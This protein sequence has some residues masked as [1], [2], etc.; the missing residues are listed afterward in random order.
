MAKGDDAMK[1]F[2]M[3]T[4][5]MTVSIA[6]YTRIA[7]QE[8]NI[9]EFEFTVVEK[10]ST[11]TSAL[12]PIDSGAVTKTYFRRSDGTSGHIIRETRNGRTATTANYLSPN[13][14]AEVVVQV[15][16][17][18]QS[19]YPVPPDVVRH[20]ISPPVRSQC[21]GKYNG[22][23]RVGETQLFGV[24]VEILRLVSSDEEGDFYVAPSLDCATLEEHHKWKDQAGNVVSLTDVELV[25]LKLGPPSPTYFELD[26]GAR[27]AA[28]SE[29]RGVIRSLLFPGEL[30]PECWMQVNE[31]VDSV[32]HR[33]REEAAKG[34]PRL[35]IVKGSQ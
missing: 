24:P 32:Y 34:W 35:P 33:R 4:A 6:M 30:V 22:S 12:P 10:L 18:I 31:R 27:E 16:G 26:A 2:L 5:I 25:D 29:A 14:S 8:Q 7:A 15:E 19:T 9:G 20:W 13:R 21:T 3:A 11:V 1:R 23:D 28:P 17:G